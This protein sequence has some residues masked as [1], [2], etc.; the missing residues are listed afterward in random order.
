M[1]PLNLSLTEL[2]EKLDQDVPKGT[3]LEKITEAQ[4]RSHTLNALGDQ[5]VG[6]YVAQAKAEGASWSEIGDAIGVT[7][8]AAQQRHSPQIFERFTNHARHAIVLAQE[9][10]RSHKHN[11]I[12]T[13]HVLLG[14]L[15]VPEGLAYEML[16][17]EAGSEDAVRKAVDGQ[18]QPPEKKA[19]RGHIAFTPTSKEALDATIQA[20]KDW[21]HDFVGTEHVLV[22]L[23]A[24]PSGAGAIALSTLGITQETMRPKIQAELTRRLAEGKTAN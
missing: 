13:E 22:G 21:G 5:L 19:P 23:L 10:A 20:A 11:F 6:H 2:I 3:A 14:L 17:R 1:S 16:V 9:A 24:V 15:G 4:L 8:Q 18:L 7:K 12:G